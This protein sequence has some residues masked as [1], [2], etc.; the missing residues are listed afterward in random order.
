MKD[1]FVST[2][3][4]RGQVRSLVEAVFCRIG[5]KKSYRF[6]SGKSS[7]LSLTVIVWCAIIIMDTMEYVKS[8]MF[9]EWNKYVA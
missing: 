6:P 5:W 7:E 8:T 1:S 3:D 4:I 2:I 9:E